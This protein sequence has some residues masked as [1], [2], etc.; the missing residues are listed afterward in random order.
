MDGFIKQNDHYVYTAKGPWLG[1]SLAADPEIKLFGLRYDDLKQ[2]GDR[3]QATTIAQF[4]KLVQPGLILTHHIFKGLERRLCC[5]DDMEGDRNK[6]VYVRKPSYDFYWE[7]GPQ[8]KAVRCDAPQGQVFA[9][10]VSPNINHREQYPDIVGWL[11]RWNW[12]D[13]DTC[14]SEAPDDWFDRYESKLWT[15]GEMYE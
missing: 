1:Q 12:V 2:Y 4:Y 6:L 9:V 13:E 3:G 11:D 5:D 15:L 10:I 8:G 14:L 7:G